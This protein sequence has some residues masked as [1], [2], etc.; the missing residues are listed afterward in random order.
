MS[1]ETIRRSDVAATVWDTAVREARQAHFMFEG[2]YMDY[3]ADRFVDASLL[4]LDNSRTV[5]AIPASMRGDEVTSHAGLTFGGIL[6]NEAVGAADILEVASVTLEAWRAQGAAS[7]I[8]KPVPHIYHLV[9]A[10]D[11][12]FAWHRHGARLQNR[13]LAQV[14]RN[15][16]A[17]PWSAERKRAVR[18]AHDSELEISRSDAIEEYMALLSELLL[19]RYGAAPAHSTQEMRLLVDRFP[20]G[21]KLFEA[22]HAGELLSGVLIYETP[23]VAHAQYIASSDRGHELR[24]QDALFEHLLTE[25]YPDKPWFDFGTSNESDGN[26]N[27]GLVRNKEGFGARS[28]TYDRYVITI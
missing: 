3:H 7:V 27:T 24:A 18:R 25:V 23:R 28:V 21:I 19:R 11:E 1:L 26:I 6:A 4:I 8:V 9:P 10:E 22:R 20:D 16:T 12:L 14:V 15:G 17:T 5:A 2:A 13:N